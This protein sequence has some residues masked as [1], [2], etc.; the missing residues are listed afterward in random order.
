M[1]AGSVLNGRYQLEREVGAGGFARVYLARDLLL[2]RRVAL[3]V[4]HPQFADDA[5]IRDFRVR[6]DREAQAVA[7]LDHPHILPVYDYGEAD[8][9]VYLVR[10]YVDGGTLF[11]RLREQ[12]ALALP[13]VAAWVTQAAAALDHAHRTGLVHRDVKPHNMLLRAADDRLLLA[14]FGIAKVLGNTDDQ[15]R[16]GAIGTLAYMAPEQFQG[17]VAPATD[18]YALGCV[19]F[20]LLTGD[21]P[22]TGPTEQVMYGH[23]VAPIP[24]LA[25]QIGRPLPPGL[26]GVIDR[27]L[28]KRAEERFASA[29]ALAQALHRAL[30]SAPTPADDAPT[31]QL[32][33]TGWATR[34]HHQVGHHA[35]APDRCRRPGARAH[36]VRGAR[37]PRRRESA[38]RTSRARRT[39]RG[40]PRR[41]PAPGRRG[42]R[43]RR[44]GRGAAQRV[45]DAD[46]PA[47]AGGARHSV[48]DW[49]ARDSDQPAGV[50]DPRPDPRAHGRRQRGAHT[51]ARGGAGCA[52]DPHRP[53]HYPPADRDR[54]G[55]DS[56]TRAPDL[57]AR[58]HHD[59]ADADAS[60]A[61]THYN[62]DASDATSCVREW[63]ALHEFQSLPTRR[64]I[65]S[66]GWDALRT[67]R[68]GD[69]WRRRRL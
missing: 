57:A 14:D 44:A 53:D 28:A 33:K 67:T 64:G 56:H 12:R 29:G 8:G 45:G 50:A 6:F 21:V 62:P 41:V 18:T 42:V 63:T 37:G 1:A 32:E 52:G 23:L 31:E 11:D 39:P 34:A 49:R 19:L 38:T 43:V 26:Q 35:A 15:S 40:R 10:P 66:R 58:A 54:A 2:Q 25:A 27:A 60:P 7:A 59:P 4:L 69:L 13:T 3:K 65:P 5:G 36:A 22:F 17:R 61:T 47:R 24:A 55:P 9:L 20:Q 30:G 48:G 46:R 16:T 51:D 68:S